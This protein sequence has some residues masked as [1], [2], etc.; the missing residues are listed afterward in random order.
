MLKMFIFLIFLPG[1]CLC[2]DCGSI[3][4]SVDHIYSNL[5]VEE[6]SAR[7]RDGPKGAALSDHYPVE[8]KLTGPL[9]A[10]EWHPAQ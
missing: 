2:D 9:L 6:E 5:C 3:M 10:N 1:R 8:S 7:L 4:H